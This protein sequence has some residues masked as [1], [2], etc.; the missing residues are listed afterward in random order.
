MST[1][2]F[3]FLGMGFSIVGLGF[4]LAALWLIYEAYK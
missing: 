2:T 4:S 1:E 3:S